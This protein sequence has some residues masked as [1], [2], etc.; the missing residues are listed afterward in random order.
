MSSM[1]PARGLEP[2]AMSYAS[3]YRGRY[4]EDPKTSSGSQKA[5]AGRVK[6]LCHQAEASTLEPGSHA[7]GEDQGFL[8]ENSSNFQRQREPELPNNEN[9]QVRI[10]KTSHSKLLPENQ[11]KPSSPPGLVLCC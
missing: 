1:R 10:R 9:S 4:K 8:D 5:Y 6:Y 3:L 7:H 2:T 11:S